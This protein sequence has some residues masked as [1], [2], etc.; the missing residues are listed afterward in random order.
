MQGHHVEDI[1]SGFIVYEVKGDIGLMHY[2]RF[3]ELRTDER[4]V[5][6]TSM[7]AYATEL[8]DAL[9]KTMCFTKS[10]SVE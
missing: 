10:S 7:L 6:D 8:L 2:Y 9:N 4:T 5:D 1:I 3:P